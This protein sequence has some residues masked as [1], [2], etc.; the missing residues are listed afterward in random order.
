MDIKEYLQSISKRE[1][2]LNAMK[3]RH[4]LLL[5]MAANGSSPKMDDMPRGVK[6]MGSSMENLVCKAVDLEVQI[7][8]EQEELDRNKCIILEAISSLPDPDLQTVVLLRY[9]S[10]CSWKDVAES[11][12]RSLS[13][14]YKAHGEALS[15]LRLKLEVV[16]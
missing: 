14:V 3:Q 15:Q 16:A 9:F 2:R 10:H 4:E 11:M 7:R 6:P 1:Y 12:Y 8:K 13:W 5:S